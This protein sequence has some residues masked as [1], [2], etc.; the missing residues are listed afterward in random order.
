MSNLPLLAIAISTICIA[1]QSERGIFDLFSYL[2]LFHQ[3]KSRESAS[4]YD[5]LEKKTVFI[6]IP[7]LREQ[8]IAEDAILGFCRLAHEHLNIKIVILTSEKELTERQEFSQLI[9]E[10]IILGSIQKGKLSAYKDMIMIIR[11]PNARGNMATQLNYG[12]KIIA[13]TA[14]GKSFYM[15]YNADSV[16]SQRTFDKLANLIDQYPNKEFAVQQPCAFVKEMNPQSNN[17]T[18]AM[19]LYQSWY[20][21]GHESRIVRNYAKRSEKWWGRK[22]GK[23]GVVVGHGSGM[24]I[25]IHC[26]NGG[27]PSELLTEDLTFGFILST[28]N[29]PILSLPALELADVPTHFSVFIKQKSVWFW[30]FLGYGNCYRKMLCQGYPLPKTTSLLIQ[31]IGAGAYWFLDTY[32]ILIPLI[33]SLYYKSSHGVA[34]SILSFLIFY[35]LPQYI[36]FKLLPNILDNQGFSSYAK[37]VRKVSFVKILPTLCLI[38]MTNSVGPWIATVKWLRYMVTGRLPAKY[39][40]GN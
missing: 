26:S 7:M 31:G 34:I 36:L 40:T 23:L 35:I 4:Q 33:I 18:N 3:L 8:A 20:C 15:V 25:N 24:T 13:E 21:L 12:L 10:D 32:F 11:D 27:Y 9:T 2:R 5:H 39:K 17:F 37:N 22:N 29:I 28:K 19:S 30:N 6:L 16:L 1:L 38:I 14:S